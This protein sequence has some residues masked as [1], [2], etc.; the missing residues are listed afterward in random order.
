MYTHYLKSVCSNITLTH[1]FKAEQLVLNLQMLIKDCN[2][3]E[4]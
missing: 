4:A 3:N 2:T 1:V